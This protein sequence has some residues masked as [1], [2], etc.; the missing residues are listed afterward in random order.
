MSVPSNR[1]RQL[2]VAG[3]SSPI[4][5]VA[6]GGGDSTV[7]AQGAETAVGNSQ[8]SIPLTT[9][10]VLP[11]SASLDDAAA[12]E[13]TSWNYGVEDDAPQSLSAGSVPCTW[14]AAPAAKTR[15]NT[16]YVS[17]S[18]ND[19]NDGS[20]TAPWRSI[21]GPIDSGLIPPNTTLRIMGKSWAPPPGQMMI[22]T[23]GGA[24]TPPDG[25]SIVP[26]RGYRQCL[27]D[28]TGRGQ[29]M[30]I[31][32]WYPDTVKQDFEIWGFRISNWKAD[33]VDG[34]DAPVII[35]GNWDGVRIVGNRWANNGTANGSLGHILYLSGGL[36]YSQATRNV[37][38]S[39]NTIVHPANQGHLIK[40]GSGGGGSA[41]PD[42]DQDPG[43]N[44]HDVLIEYNYLEAKGWGGLIVTGEY[45]AESPANTVIANNIIRVEGLGLLDSDGSIST[46]MYGGP[47]YFASNLPWGVGCDPSFVV[48]E[49][50]IEITS[51]DR[52]DW[53]CIYNL[54][55]PANVTQPNPHAPILLNNRL[56]NG[57]FPTKL[58]AG[59]PMGANIAV[60]TIDTSCAS[61]LLTL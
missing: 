29:G 39:H 5:L 55:S 2:L 34:G 48:R 28:G 4:V 12:S 42:G 40:I 51:T 1:R 58:L 49:N 9:G 61:R 31:Q 50:S 30:L 3:L 24:A 26:D 15:A 32:L 46:A 41:G 13:V 54:R 56:R 52:T 22:D 57:S 27:I 59:A 47:V 36:S 53:H 60:G 19:Q 21:Q 33:T 45:Q 7:S 11:L 17:N 10:N 38:V 37:L 25:L 18:G 6:C 20:A 16:R 14:P 44:P 23:F 43:S 35:G 8:V